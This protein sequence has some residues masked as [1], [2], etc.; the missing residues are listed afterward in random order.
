MLSDVNAAGGVYDYKQNGADWPGDYSDCGL[1][2]QSP[3]NLNSAY[4]AYQRYDK[5]EDLYTKVYAN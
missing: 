4:D 1:Q 5:T 2:N 3:I